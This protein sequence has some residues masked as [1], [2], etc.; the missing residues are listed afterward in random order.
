MINEGRQKWFRSAIGTL[1]YLVKL[2]RP[3]LANSVREL[4]KVMDGA[5]QTQEKE[6]KRMIGYK[7]QKKKGF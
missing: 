1:L 5:N 3:D 7:I 2:S 4:A 6:L